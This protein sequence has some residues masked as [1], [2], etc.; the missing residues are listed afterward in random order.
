MNTQTILQ[1][2]MREQ[3]LAHKSRNPNGSL[4]SFAKRVGIH[5]SALSHILNG[6]R[7]ITQKQLTKILNNLNIDPEK[8]KKLLGLL[9]PV[10]I[11]SFKENIQLEAVAFKV[12][13][14]WENYAVLSLINC[15][16][17]KFDLGWMALRLGISESKVKHCLDCLMQLKL[18]SISEGNLTRTNL[19]IST[20]DETINLSI[21]KSHDENLKLASE[22]LYR[23]SNSQR[24]FTCVT[25]AIAP[26]QI[27]LAK[28][29]IRKFQ[30]EISSVLE[31]GDLTEVYRMSI[32]LFPLTKINQP[33]Q[34]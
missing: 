1:N 33:L 30:D 14:E 5:A 28:E 34:H 15:S 19:N 21:R 32:Q 8:K 20:S 18:V 23:D 29:M 27:P 7:N 3:L 26:N 9:Q 22:S 12:I 6:N 4:R 31:S 24:D 10:A 11:K 16:D 17:F 13:S 2:F 25:M